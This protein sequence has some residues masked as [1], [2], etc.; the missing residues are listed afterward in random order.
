MR[1]VRALGAALALAAL[2]A[3]LAGCGTS[4]PLPTESRR[5]SFPV[6][7]SYQLISPWTGMANVHDIL[8][9][10][11]YGQQLFI[12]F[13]RPV[14][15][16]TNSHGSAHLY[17]LTQPNAIP[18]TEF[19]HLNNPVALA[20][21][22]DGAGAPLRRIFVLDRGDT[23]VARAN[24]RTGKLPCTPFGPVPGDTTG[25]WT[26]GVSNL[27]HY[28][29]VLEY[30]LLGGDTLSTFTDT[31]MADVAGIAAD[32]Q[33]RVY[34]S[35]IAIILEADISN[36]RIVTRQFESRIYRYE[37]G[38]RYPGVVPPDRRM[39]GANWHRDS[40]WQVI[41]GSGIGSVM[42]PHRI[43]W[44]QTPDGTSLYVSDYGK[45]WIQRLSDDQPSSGFYFID[46]A[47]TGAFFYQA[48]DVAVDADG[49]VYVCDTGNRRV[50]RYAADKSFVQRVDISD[51]GGSGPLVRPVAIAANDT[52]VYI[53]DPGSSIVYRMRRR[54]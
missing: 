30:G 13:S 44:L 48:E 49:F 31:T 11:T 21:G 24:P 25:G 4:F 37:R 5:T 42:N 28:S 1:P 16:D 40:T 3:P 35:G 32:A 14:P 36:P 33:G 34:V 7:S 39:P 26:G 23:C 54:K 38:P 18:G 51:V 15:D 20:A 45:N 50:L 43:D 46:G 27:F 19:L 9:T 52:L 8:L 53:A 29:R 17:P 22:G 12:L 2:A 10:Q 47:E 41:E 6:D